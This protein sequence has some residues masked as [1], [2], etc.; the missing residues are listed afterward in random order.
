MMRLRAKVPSFIRGL[1]VGLR[2]ICSLKS[3]MPGNTSVWNQDGAHQPLGLER[4]HG[5][6]REL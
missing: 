2:Q 3:M 6:M 1:S 5:L 4:P